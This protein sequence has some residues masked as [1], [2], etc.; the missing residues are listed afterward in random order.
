MPAQ[1]KSQ[2]R[3]MAQALGIKRKEI[4]VSDLDPKYRDEIVKLSKSMTEKELEAF[5]S[6]KTKDL[7]HHVDEKGIPVSGFTPV[8]KKSGLNDVFE[9]E[10]PMGIKPF[11]NPE[12]EKKKKGKK[13]LQNLKDYRDWISKK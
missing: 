2:Q 9:P 11:L 4:K 5:A 13:N 3:L 10:G 8:V 12:V 6:T 7:P 1:S